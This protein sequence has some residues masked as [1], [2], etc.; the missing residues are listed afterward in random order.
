M[1]QTS[2]N[3]KFVHQ[4][5]LAVFGC[6]GVLFGEG[7]DSESLEICDSFDFINRSKISFPEFFDGLE[8]LME[9]FLIDLFRKVEDPEF[10]SGGVSR[11]ETVEFV[12]RN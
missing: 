6:E 2:Q 4:T 9:T 5:F 3:C 10:K 11:V 12:G 7:L 8:K 1:V